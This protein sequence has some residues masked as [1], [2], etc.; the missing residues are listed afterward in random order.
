[1]Y[2]ENADSIEKQEKAEA[3]EQKKLTEAN[4]Q[5]EPEEQG[6]MSIR[7]SIFDDLDELYNPKPAK[8][9]KRMRRKLEKMEAIKEEI[10][11]KINGEL[12][13]VTN[14]IFRKG[15]I[16]IPMETEEEDSGGG[17]SS[18]YYLNENIKEFE[19]YI[20]IDIPKKRVT[21]ME[22]D[23]D[24]NRETTQHTVPL[25]PSWLRAFKS[26]K[27]PHTQSIDLDNIISDLADNKFYS[28]DSLYDYLQENNRPKNQLLKGGKQLNIS[29]ALFEDDDD[30]L[31]SKSDKE[32]I[33]SG[34]F[35]DKSDDDDD[36]ID[37]IVDDDGRS[38]KV[39][40]SRIYRRT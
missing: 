34:L 20:I 27:W 19:R 8:L 29:D 11:N 3:T 25:T 6:I 17:S 12:Y 2:K 31:G 4:E 5:E 40:L 30:L 16:I 7:K 39:N 26:V 36:D 32:S 13:H 24:Y 1:M 10:L 9:S 15:Q 35:S 14:K 21:A 28:S 38:S 18:Y 23:L 22:I 33:L 37:D